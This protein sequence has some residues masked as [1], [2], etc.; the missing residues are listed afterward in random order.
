MSQPGMHVFAKFL[1]DSLRR[2]LV[3]TDWQEKFA[4]LPTVI[5]RK[6]NQDGTW[7]RVWV[8]YESYQTREFKVGLIILREFR[9]N[10][11][12]KVYRWRERVR[13]L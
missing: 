2:G 13:Y 6:K 7:E 4:Y 5:G 3:K 12:S 8:F 9:L 11:D 10:A 1:D